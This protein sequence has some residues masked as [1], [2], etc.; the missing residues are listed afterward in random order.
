[1][2]PILPELRRVLR[3][4]QPPSKLRLAATALVRVRAKLVL[5]LLR[6]WQP[7]PWLGVVRVTGGEQ[8]CSGVSVVHDA[9]ELQWDCSMVSISLHHLVL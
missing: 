4:Q 7:V 6:V 3:Q 9:K 2:A 8:G 1:V 5:S